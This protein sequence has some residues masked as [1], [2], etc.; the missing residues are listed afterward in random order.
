MGTKMLRKTAFGAVIWVIILAVAVTTATFA[1]FTYR[2]AANVEPMSGTING[3]DISLLISDSAS[4]PFDVSCRLP[5]THQTEELLPVTTSD[6]N[7]FYVVSAQNKEGIATSYAPVGAGYDTYMLHGTV[8]LLAED[9][10]CN[11]F[12]FRDRL[13]FGSDIQALSAMRLGMR[14]S[15]QS[16]THSYIFRLD[17]MADTSSADSRVTVLNRGSVY[18]SGGYAPDPAVS[19]MPYC[20]TGTAENPSAGSVMLCQLNADEV[21]SCEFWLY[22]EG[23]DDNCFNPVQARDLALSFGFA[24]F[25]R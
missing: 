10:A 13:N 21:A 17:D 9:A 20:A 7:G 25:A 6:L 24:G 1:W 22:M 18:G 23:C 15:T 5:F 8:Y 14:F 3:D 2:G 12:F 19:L 11:V 4:G 16:G